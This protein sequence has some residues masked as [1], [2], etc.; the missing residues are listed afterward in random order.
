MDQNIFKAV[1]NSRMSLGEIYFWTN[2]I[3]DW[4]HLLKKD[5]YKELIIEQL[6]WLKKRNK[7]II[8]G[9]V[10]MPNHVHIL[11]ELLGKNGVGRC[12]GITTNGRIPLIDLCTFNLSKSCS[13]IKIRR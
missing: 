8:Y 2:T 12:R 3:K 7:I 11:W 9:L 5:L 6:Q 4:K 1:R 10:I 13:P